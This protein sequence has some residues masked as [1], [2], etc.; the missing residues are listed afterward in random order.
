MSSLPLA[1]SSSPARR[2]LSLDGPPRF[3]V[4]VP[5]PIVE[6]QVQVN[7]PPSPARWVFSPRRAPLTALCSLLSALCSLHCSLYFFPYTLTVHGLSHLLPHLA[8]ASELLAAGVLLVL[9]LPDQGKGQVHVLCQLQY[10]VQAGILK[11][12]LS[13]GISNLNSKS[14]ICVRYMFNFLYNFRHNFRYSRYTPDSLPAPAN[15]VPHI[16]V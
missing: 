4:V 1:S 2:H 12:T 16:P 8:P 9:L 11:A 15:P 14:G 3:T 6:G 13:R 5:V 7:A 10:Q